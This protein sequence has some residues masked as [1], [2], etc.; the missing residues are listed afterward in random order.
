M[1]SFFRD[2][3]NKKFL[4]GFV[5]LRPPVYTVVVIYLDGYKK[6]YQGISN[7]WKYI[8]K[9]KINPK[10]KTAYVKP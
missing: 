5:P 3:N 7:P 4:D 10:I 2:G 9:V 1:H 6:E 8:A